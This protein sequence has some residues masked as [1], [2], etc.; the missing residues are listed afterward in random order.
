MSV[1]SG[2][3]S[4]RG[5]LEMYSPFQ[6]MSAGEVD[7]ELNRLN[8]HQ[9]ANKIILITVL[10]AVYP[11]NVELVS[12]ICKPVASPVRIVIFSKVFVQIMIEFD[13]EEAAAKAKEELHSADIYPGSCTLKVEYAKTN[14][15]NVKKNDAMTW[16]FTAV[17]PNNETSNSSSGGERKVLFKEPPQQPEN[18]AR[19]TLF[20]NPGAAAASGG[21][22]MGSV[23]DNQQ[24]YGG[25]MSNQ[26]SMNSG[27]MPVSNGM[28]S[29]QGGVAGMGNSRRG[30]DRG[31]RD[32]RRPSNREY[33][34]NSTGGGGGYVA[35]DW[36]GGYQGQQHQQQGGYQA[37]GPP[38]S[39]RVLML[40]GLEDR[41][42]CQGVFN[43]FCVYGDVMRVSYMKKKPGCAMVEMDSAASADRVLQHYRNK[44]IFGQQL[45]LE[46]S[47]K[48]QIEEI[49]MP[50][51]LP[52]RSPSY[53]DFAASH[54]LR[55]STEE[56]AMKNRI[57]APTSVLHFFNVASISDDEM[58]DLFTRAGAPCPTSVKWF[59]QKPG[60]KSASGLLMFDTVSEA[61]EALVLG[62]HAAA[63]NPNNEN[64][65][66]TMKLCYS[67]SKPRDS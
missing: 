34:N 66:Y 5:R 42:N 64:K 57:V 13:D 44:N 9:T 39:G 22:M 30:H 58:C 2:P 31:E 25:G 60:A 23:M 15:L 33:S 11:V 6:P 37:S 27:G 41:V 63:P 1:S 61:M 7:A 20:Q 50:H 40:Y 48:P 46:R 19:P 59:E 49:R 24:M 32:T 26:F 35:G 21:G 36:G 51:E 4:K 62:N 54:N 10:N 28:N 43:L 18:V 17:L 67:N 55:F 14:K 65:P 52:D 8:P 45:M 29:M 16:D 56:K 47:R 53:T 38:G 3:P 12:K